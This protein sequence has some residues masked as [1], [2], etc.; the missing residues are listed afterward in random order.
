M[1]RAIL[2]LVLSSA[3]FCGCT[4]VMSAIPPSP[5]QE[6]LEKALGENKRL[7]ESLEAEIQVNHR[8]AYELEMARIDLLKAQ[9][10]LTAAQAKAAP[11]VPAFQ[12]YQV[13]RV[14]LGLLTGPADWDQ[15]HGYDGIAAYLLLKDGDGDVIKRKGN[16]VFDLI[17]VARSKQDVVMSWAVPADVLGANWQSLPR[18]F[19]LKLPWQG[20]VPYGDDCVLRASFTDAFG[21]SFTAS[22]LLHLEEQPQREEPQEAPK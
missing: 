19:R 13:E 20:D 7:Q 5:R 8:L 22:R 9:A 11:T 2:S 14:D 6:P 12:D 18:G 4:S 15:A 21:R 16:C 3:V 17:D 10:G 1:K